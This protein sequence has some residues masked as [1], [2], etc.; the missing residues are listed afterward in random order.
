MIHSLE[1]I[2]MFSEQLLIIVCI[3]KLWKPSNNKP[4][5]ISSL[6]KIFPFINH[7]ILRMEKPKQMH[8]DMLIR[9]YSIFISNSKNPD[10][11]KTVSS[12][13]LPIIEKWKN[14]RKEKKQHSETIDM[15]ED[16]L[17]SSVPE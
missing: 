1:K 8:S 5:H 4:D 17:L 3:K 13:S 12:S 9:V 7:T 11:S 14:S 2:R 16:S 6:Y 15:L 10:S